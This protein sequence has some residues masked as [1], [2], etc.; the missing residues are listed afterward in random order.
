M[1]AFNFLLLILNIVI[2]EIFLYTCIYKLNKIYKK[3]DKIED[4]NLNRYKE[5][6]KLI[7]NNKN[8]ECQ[9]E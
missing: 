2:I 1:I 3:I 4:D 8:K 7:E 5:L 6:K 9:Q